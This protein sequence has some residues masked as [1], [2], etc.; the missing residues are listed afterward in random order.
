MS[1]RNILI[2]YLVSGLWH[3]A[4]W[5]YIIWGGLNGLYFIPIFLIK[6]EKYAEVVAYGK[7]FPT[8]KEIWQILF[9]FSLCTFSWVFFRTENMPHAMSYLDG[10]F[11]ASLFTMP[12]ITDDKPGNLFTVVLIGFIILEWIGRDSQFA[13]DKW[14]AWF[15]KPLRISVY[16]GLILLIFYFSGSSE[17]FIYFQF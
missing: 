3:G 6:N 1:I 14:I 16:L 8:V 5:N 13:L 11:D 4:G 9:T 2:V 10:I 17:Q 12:Y 7:V 15:N